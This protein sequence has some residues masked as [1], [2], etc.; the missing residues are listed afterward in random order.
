MARQKQLSILRWGSQ[1]CATANEQIDARQ[2]QNSI[3]SNKYLQKSDSVN[4]YLF[5]PDTLST[6]DICKSI[7]GGY[8]T[9]QRQ[10]IHLYRVQ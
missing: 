3:I 5:R 4:S 6:C 8:K 9:P 10:Y 1:T 7:A 2:R